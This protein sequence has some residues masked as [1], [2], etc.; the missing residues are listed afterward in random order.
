[1]SRNSWH[2]SNS[3]HCPPR[4]GVGTSSCACNSESSDTVAPAHRCDGTRPVPLPTDRP[5]QPRISRQTEH[6]ADT[7]VL[8]PAHQRLSAKPRIAANHG[9]GLRPALADLLHD[10]LQLLHAAG[11]GVDIR[12]TQPHT[13]GARFRRFTAADNSSGGSNCEKTAPPD[14]R[15]AD[16][17]WRLDPARSLSAPWHKTR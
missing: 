5:H 12:V 3:P 10:P 4:A 6:I 9:T 14:D 15:A 13:A 1:M 8:A 7:A 11:R 17:M 2:F 16:R